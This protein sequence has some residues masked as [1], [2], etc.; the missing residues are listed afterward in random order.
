MLK[1]EWYVIKLARQ[2]YTQTKNI[3]ITPLFPCSSTNMGE[4]DPRFDQELQQYPYKCMVSEQYQTAHP[5]MHFPDD[6]GCFNILSKVLEE[7]NFT[8]D[9]D[10]GMIMSEEAL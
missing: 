2:Y 9:I 3:K 5:T 7:G 8:S 6:N 4:A 10:Q 1:L